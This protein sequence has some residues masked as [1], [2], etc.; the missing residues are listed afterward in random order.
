MSRTCE[1]SLLLLWLDQKDYVYFRIL[2]ILKE[3]EYTTSC[4]YKSEQEGD[5]SEDQK[6]SLGKSRPEW[7]HDS[8]K[9]LKFCRTQKGVGS[10][11]Y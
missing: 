9:H 10:N 3:P 8:I 2:L 7:E 11:A 1:R 4:P 6:L 5:G